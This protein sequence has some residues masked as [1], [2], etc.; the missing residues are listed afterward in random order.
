MCTIRLYFCWHMFC[1][2]RFLGRINSRQQSHC[3]LLYSGMLHCLLS[4]IKCQCY[5]NCYI[6]LKL[7]YFS[8]CSEASW[9]PYANESLLS[10]FQSFFVWVFIRR[11][12]YVHTTSSLV[13]HKSRKL[14]IFSAGRN[15][16]LMLHVALVHVAYL[17][18]TTAF[19]VICIINCD[20]CHTSFGYRMEMAPLTSE[21]M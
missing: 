2:W 12:K 16:N 7:V 3:W 20:T 4:F 9:R 1:C 21:N 17:I 14:F 13:I 6:Y 19:E 8:S 10:C 15:N 11:W 5:R 18:C